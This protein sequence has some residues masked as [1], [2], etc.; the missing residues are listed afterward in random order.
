MKTVLFDLGGVLI[1]WN[2]DW[3][4]D[5]ISSQ[6]GKPFNDI[7]SKFNDNLC[8]L[9]ETKIKESKFCDIDLGSNN[10]IDK[11]IIS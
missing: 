11:K 6:M 10:D 9:F 3:L 8:R 2:D 5:E 1:N 7:K 4:Y